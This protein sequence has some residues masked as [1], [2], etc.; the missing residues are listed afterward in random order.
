[1]LRDVDT[2]KR[3]YEGVMQRLNQTNLDSQANRTNVSVL[4]PAVEPIEPSFPRPLEQMLMIAAALGL[5][6][7]GA[8]AY[9]LEMLDRRVRSPE[10]LAEMLQFPVLGVID[11]GEPRS[12]LGFNRRPAL[13]AK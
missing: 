1:L 12:L 6:L 9:G 3:A 2:A 11:P 7:A 8:A 13:T 10:D 4:T 5:A